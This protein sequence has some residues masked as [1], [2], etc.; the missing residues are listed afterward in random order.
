MPLLFFHGIAPGGLILY[1][2]M[3][4]FGLAT[5]PERPVF[6]FENRSISCSMDFYPLSEEKTVDGI[7]ELVNQA[8][9]ESSSQEPL[10]VVGHSFGSCPITWLLA[11]PKMS[12][13]I[14][15]VVLLDPV[16]ILLSE[17]DV[18]V[19]FLYAQEMDKIRMVASSELFTEYYLRRHFAWY[20]SE[21]WLQDLKEQHKLL[22]CLSEQDE[23]INARKVRQELERHASE[24]P[25][26]HQPK[27]L[28]WKEAGHG[29]C[30]SS[31]S[32]W[33]QIKGLML[34]QELEILQQRQCT[35]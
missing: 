24:V 34:Q 1:L 20:N 18:M 35:N 21:L 5:E 16:A 31:L 27:T 11:S 14:H 25:E 13:R 19:N 33:R 30:I 23:I 12:S 7:F 26:Q 3:I 10:S 29:A 28:Y 2:P 15:Q 22:V 32:K 8:L 4:F 9:G 6:L 17:P